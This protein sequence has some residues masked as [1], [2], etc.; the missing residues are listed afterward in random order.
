MKHFV[1]ICFLQLS[2]I[3][4]DDR[5][6]MDASF[7]FIKVIGKLQMHTMGFETTTSLSTWHLQGEEV[8]IELELIGSS[9]TGL[10]WTII[11]LL[12]YYRENCSL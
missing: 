6:V 12:S 11:S 4:V 3:T 10:P 8:P 7:S 5:F 9:T 2:N 1:N